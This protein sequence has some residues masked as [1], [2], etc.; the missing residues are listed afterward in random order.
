MKYYIGI[1]IGGTAIKSGIVSEVGEILLTEITE[2]YFDDYKTPLWETTLK[3]TKNIFEKSKELD[4]KIEGIGF[5]VTGDVDTNENVIVGGC[6][7]IPNWKNINIQKD[8]DDYLGVALKI[9]SVNDA[10]AAAIAER[11][12]GSAKGFDDVIVYTIGTGI[13]GGIFVKGKILNGS[14]GFAGNIGHMVIADGKDKCPCGNTGCFEKMASTRN[15]VKH[16]VEKGLDINGKELFDVSNDNIIAK[17]IVEEFFNY[18]GIAIGNLIHIFNP[19]AI[20]IGGGIS[21][22]GQ[23]FIDRIKESAKL[24]TLPHFFDG[25]EFKQAKLTNDAGLVGAVKYYI[26]KMEK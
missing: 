23:W 21:N 13:G 6:G 7:S 11:W 2:A 8:L 3:A 22:Q 14:R 16:C 20:V 9:S 24:H 5:S 10:N 19:K 1:D 26:D 25:V 17:A 12:Q 15:I 18:H 4:L